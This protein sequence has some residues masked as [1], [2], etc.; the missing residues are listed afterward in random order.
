MKRASV[1]LCM[2]VLM[3]TTGCAERLTPEQARQSD[4]DARASH[5]AAAAAAIPAGVTTATKAACE[6]DLSSRADGS[7]GK[8]VHT[9]ESVDF[10]GSVSE[11][12]LRNR[13][14][15]FDIETL[16]S[17][18]MTATGQRLESTKICRV[19]DDG[20]VEWLPS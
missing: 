10:V 13:P 14:H 1:S 17:V 12:N 11:Y 5:S 7:S 16:Y 18:R 3:L 6:A 4:L 9:L 20:R 2:V 19:R 15:A 8:Y